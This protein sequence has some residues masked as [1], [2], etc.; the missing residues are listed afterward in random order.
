M[1][2]SVL[3]SGFDVYGWNGSSYTT[4]NSASGAYIA[5]GQGFM[6][7]A[8]SSSSANLTFTTGM[9]STSNSSMDDFI[10]GDQ[11][12]DRAELF[13]GYSSSGYTNKAEIYF[14]DNTTDSFD[15]SYDTVTIDFDHNN[16]I[17]TRLVDSSSDN[18][19]FVI[20]SLSYDEINDKAIP[21]VIHGIESQELTVN[22][23]HRTTPADIN[24]YLEDTFLNTLTNLKDEDFILTPINDLSGAGRFYIHLTEDTMS[25]SDVASNLMNAYKEADSDFITIEGLS[26]QTGEV[27]LSIYNILGSKVMSASFD[28]SLNQRIL[29]TQGISQG[30]Y[31]VELVSMGSRVTKKIL[32]K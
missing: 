6:V 11:L 28:N 27:K 30:I 23:L 10:S 29:S 1:T 20:Q 12:E 3:G 2:S 15:T 22:I 17:H 7:G 19:N 16:G 13:L 24:I 32:I 4:Y 26:S 14:L 31:I 8:D 9:Q 25:T 21:L 18:R 5:P